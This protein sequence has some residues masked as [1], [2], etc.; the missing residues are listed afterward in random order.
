MFISHCRFTV[1]FG[2]RK[3]AKKYREVGFHFCRVFRIVENARANRKMNT[4]RNNDNKK[5]RSVYCKTM[6]PI[7]FDSNILNMF[8]NRCDNIGLRIWNNRAQHRIEF[9]FEN[10]IRS[11]IAIYK[12]RFSTTTKKARVL[13][14]VSFLP[15]LSTNDIAEFNTSHIKLSLRQRHQPKWIY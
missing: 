7:R 9:A 10:V 4:V 8:S 11:K 3:Q 14:C 15:R 2:C 1:K 5:Y 6:S 12:F 13:V